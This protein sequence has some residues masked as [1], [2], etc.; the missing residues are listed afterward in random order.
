MLPA[1]RAC[2]LLT[3]S[4]FESVIIPST[5]GLL[6]AGTLHRPTT[7]DHE[8][9]VIVSHGM[10]SSKDS[11]KHTAICEAVTH[12]GFTALR[13]DFRGR[14]ES[15]GDPHELTVSNEIED[16]QAAVAH[17]R[18]L[19][20]RR[21][22]LVGSSLGGTVALLTAAV[23][24]DVTGLVTIAAPSR[25]PDRPRETWGG[26][27]VIDDSG[28]IEV[29]P[30]ERIHGDF[31]VDAARHDP[32]AAAASIT[33]PW[34]IIHGALDPVVPVDD[35]L[36]LSRAAPTADLDLRPTAGHRFSDPAEL[37]WLVRRVAA[38]VD[39]IDDGKR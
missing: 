39:S 25:L 32:I 7:N 16:L 22:A 6:L 35:A 24:H 33:C 17:L 14:G 19:G 38:F 23:K 10:L 13:F 1:R 3:V 28:H 26:S 31:F 34:L 9:G 12:R 2:I 18:E 8:L 21:I 30:G 5:G 37:D 27:G 11:N 15:D 29:A 4:H 20:L 36:L